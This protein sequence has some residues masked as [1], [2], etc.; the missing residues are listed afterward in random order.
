LLLKCGFYA[1]M[2]KSIRNIFGS[3]TCKSVKQIEGKS[4]LETGWQPMN[5]LIKDILKSYKY[6]P[7]K[8]NLYTLF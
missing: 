5:I 8:H 7:Q 6:F 1:P 3:F 2:L 4:R